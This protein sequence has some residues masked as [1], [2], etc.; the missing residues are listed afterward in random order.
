MPALINLLKDSTPIDAEGP[1][2]Y[3]VIDLPCLRRVL[4]ISS[5]IGAVTA[6]LPV[7]HISFPRSATLNL[8]CKETSL[9]RSTFQAFFVLAT[10]FL[11]T[12][13]IR[14]FSLR[15][16][17]KHNTHNLKFYFSL[18]QIRRHW[19]EILFDRPPVLLPEI[20]SCKT[21]FGSLA[22]LNLLY[23]MNEQH[24]NRLTWGDTEG[25][26]YSLLQWR[27]ELND[28]ASVQVVI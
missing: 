26:L 17:Y 12:M 3:A 2:T 18:V 10:R 20:K 16:S 13:V 21:G 28:S 8:T 1:F 22:N 23:K 27:S 11:W 9:S 5:G 24:F 15:V 25:Y 14:S 6:L 7:H 19:G 4:N